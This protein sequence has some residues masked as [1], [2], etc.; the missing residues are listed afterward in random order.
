VKDE[1]TP[2][3]ARPN[4]GLGVLGRT[5]TMAELLQPSDGSMV[6]FWC[7]RMSQQ[8][9]AGT[10][11]RGWFRAGLFWSNDGADHYAPSEVTHW[12]CLRNR[13]QCAARGCVGC[14]VCA[15]NAELTGRRGG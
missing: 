4:D 15:P 11:I 2:A 13:M 6:E 3:K 14:L 10:G 7:H 8:G 12:N 5:A 9:K 1:A